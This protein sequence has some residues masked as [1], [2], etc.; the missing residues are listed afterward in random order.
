[1]FIKTNWRKL[2]FNITWYMQ[3]WKIQV[4]DQLQIKYYVKKQ[5][6]LLNI[7]NMIS[8][9]G[10]LLQQF[11]NSLIKKS[12]GVAIKSKISSNQKLIKE[13]HK[14]PVQD[15]IA[16]VNLADFQ[17]RSKFNKEF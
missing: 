12:S 9:N 15:K 4:E 17:L 5:V 2:A 11:A 10:D 16:G 6:I 8:I 3:I 7:Q 1:M 14:S 13:L